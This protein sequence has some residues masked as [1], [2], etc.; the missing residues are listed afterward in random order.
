MKWNKKKKKKKRRA[1]DNVDGIGKLN[2][3]K[4]QKYLE[5]NQP[6]RRWK[7]WGQVQ[8]R[9]TYIVRTWSR[10]DKRLVQR[11]VCPFGVKD[12]D[13]KLVEDD[14][15]PN[16]LPKGERMHCLWMTHS[17]VQKS[18]APALMP[19]IKILELFTLF[20]VFFVSTQNSHDFGKC[21]SDTSRINQRQKLC[22]ICGISFDQKRRVLV[23]KSTA[24]WL[25]P[26]KRVGWE[27][28]SKQQTLC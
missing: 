17:T 1:V 7:N 12:Y 4:R 8:I 21:M 2:T 15:V 16:N 23:K 13:R 20:T 6:S 18:P 5:I 14:H 19:E 27:R 3:K 25:P 9:Y 24:T 26:S 28:V 11:Y 10:E 22:L